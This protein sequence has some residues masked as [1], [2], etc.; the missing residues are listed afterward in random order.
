MEYLMLDPANE[1]LN[2]MVETPWYF[3]GMPAP[4]HQWREHV[5]L[6]KRMTRHRND[7]NS[8]PERCD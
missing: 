3:L 5:G 1:S 2:E 6:E 8:I 7:L 4:L